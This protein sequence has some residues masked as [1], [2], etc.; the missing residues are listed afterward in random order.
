MTEHEGLRLMAIEMGRQCND[1]LATMNGAAARAAQ[2]AA[3]M[4]ETG[5]LVL[6]GIGGSYYVN[7]MVEPLYREAGIECRAMSPS[8]ALVSPLPLARRV[9]LFVS[10]SGESG[11]IVDLLKT[12]P[13]K[14]IRFGL[15]LNETSTLGT[16][17]EA[18]IV[19][20]GGPENAF[21][22]TRSIVLTMAMHAAILDALGQPQHA[23]REV[24]AQGDTIDLSAFAEPLAACDALVF[25]GRHVQQGMAESAALSMMELARVTAIGL[26]SGQFRHGPFEFL[27]PGIGV[28]LFRSAGPDAAS[29]PS[30]A[31]TCVDA[32]CTTLV[33]D[34]SGD[35]VGGTMQTVTF[36]TRSG[37]AAAMQYIL[38]LQVLNIAVARMTVAG[39]VG[40]PRL[41]SKVTV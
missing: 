32:G 1:A 36:P 6:Y 38:S 28:I 12:D 29:I 23:L 10:Q 19:A 30:I 8:E 35:A 27:R 20:A 13:G 25:A 4:R 5:R 11:E 7:R 37:I 3:A 40:T 39:D 9:A 41:T 17:A 16:Q 26:E 33:L 31:K 24:L 21:A 34:A 22:A 15:T 2:M 18:V 14:D